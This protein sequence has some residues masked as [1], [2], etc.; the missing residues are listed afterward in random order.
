MSELLNQN[1]F[2]ISRSS[3]FT[4]ITKFFTI[5]GGK[6]AFGAIKYVPLNEIKTLAC[7][8]IIQNDML[9]EGSPFYWE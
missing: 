8:S 9:L 7:Q 3:Y 6:K 5:N 4:I 2:S 1:I